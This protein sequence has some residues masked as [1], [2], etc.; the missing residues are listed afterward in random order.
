MSHN[1]HEQLPTPRS[2]SI[3]SG[4]SREA[5]KRWGA[6][7]TAT[8]LTLALGQVAQ[9]ADGQ[10]D[11]SFGGDGRVTLDVDGAGRQDQLF[12][13]A[14]LPD[15]RI[16]VGGSTRG[17]PPVPN[18]NN[19]DFVAAGFTDTGTLD[20]AFGTAGLTTTGI[21][22]PSPG[23]DFGNAVFLQD[24]QGEEIETRQRPLDAP[25]EA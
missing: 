6:A 21:G 25:E 16:V 12:G 11:P 9:A 18:Q 13:V 23:N 5:S 19:I 8:L 22:G 24:D 14:I 15:G 10:L 4:A 3:R 20:P 17:R 2:S 7:T 1:T